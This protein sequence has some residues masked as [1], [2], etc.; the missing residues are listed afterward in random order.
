M[1]IL[2]G[3]LVIQTFHTALPP[4]LTEFDS[5]NLQVGES[6]DSSY[7]WLLGCSLVRRIEECWGWWWVAR[8][9]AKRLAVTSPRKVCWEFAI[10]APWCY[11]FHVKDWCT[12]LQGCW[13]TVNGFTNSFSEIFFLR[14]FGFSSSYSNSCDFFNHLKVP[15]GTGFN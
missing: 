15:N 11:T 6:S 10:F 3:S 8:K 12:W 4:Q 14:E 1:Q 5:P 9:N 7:L 13:N 2:K